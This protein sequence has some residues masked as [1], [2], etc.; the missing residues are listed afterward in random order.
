LGLVCRIEVEGIE[1]LPRRGP[2]IL[3]SNHLHW[4][5]IPVLGATFPRRAT[6]FAA[7][8]WERRPVVGWILRTLGSAIF[9]HRGEVDRQA[10]QK[11]LR[12]LR[13]GRILA[14]APEG[15]RSRS[16]VLQRGKEGAAYLAARTGVPLL[17]VVAYGQEKVFKSLGRGRRARVR[18]VY[19]PPF[20]LAG[21]PGR[22]SRQQLQALTEQIM[23][24]LAVLLP[25]AYRGVYADSVQQA[26]QT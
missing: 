17:P 9:V 14:V 25:P 19:G 21:T 10:L 22:V 13:E 11:A 12:V 8:K 3:I 23:L 16:G 18:V 5:D 15:T 1:H 7:R 4:L 20:T 24:R 6:A 26:T 2:F